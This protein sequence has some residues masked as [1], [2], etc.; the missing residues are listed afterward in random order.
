[1]KNGNRHYTRQV[2]LQAIYQWQLTGQTID[3]IISAFSDKAIDMDFHY[4]T[5]AVD[6]I[7]HNNI[8]LSEIYEKFLNIDKTHLDYITVAILLLATYE[9]VKIDT[10]DHRIILNEAIILAKEYGAEDSHKFVNGI[11]EKVSGCYRQK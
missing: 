9:I 11:L 5:L 8:K 4:F 7:T 10:L 1:M 6:Y 2:I 3:D